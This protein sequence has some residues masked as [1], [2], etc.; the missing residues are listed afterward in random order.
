[1]G[2]ETTFSGIMT[3]PN[4]EK[5]YIAEM[6]VA[7]Q[8]NLWLAGSGTDADFEFVDDDDFE[9]VDEDD[10]TFVG[11]GVG[12]VYR[13]DFLDE[14]ITFSDGHTEYFR[15]ILSSI[16][17]DGVELTKKT[18][19][20]DVVSA[21]GSWYQDISTGLVYVNTTDSSNPNGHYI[22]GF[23]QLR[24]S[25]KAI[26]LDGNFYEPYISEKGI[27]TI[28]YRSKEIY[29]GSEVITS[30]SISLIN[31]DGFFDQIF[32]TFI[33]SSKQITIKLG[34]DQLPY[35]EYSTIFTGTIQG[36]RFT[37]RSVEF[38]LK[39]KSFDLFQSIPLDKFT[40]SVYVNM[41]PDKEGVPIPYYYGVYSEQQAPIVTCINTGAAPVYSFKIC[42]HP[43]YSI[44]QVYIDYNDG[45]GWQAIAHSNENL[46]YATFDISSADFAIGTTKV[47]VAFSGI[48][49]SSVV[50][51]PA[52][53]VENILT[54]I[55]SYTGAD[56]DST[57]FSESV[58]ESDVVLNV[59]K[60]FS[61]I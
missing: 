4:S 42:D 36:K 15:K 34:G 11:A 49:D 54:S 2:S 21:T 57:S 46:T 24:L 48:Y 59:V 29:W 56:I 55:L 60:M 32:R 44:S 25:T 14:T 20:A 31:N 27:P 50:E 6:V 45:D 19:S 10:F 16:T 9:F 58:T 53:I 8:L 7:Q 22:V 18:S 23:F 17:E 39:A 52:D 33:W 40:A 26:E 41:D 43:I 37:R 61:R 30:G 28:H 13:H 35:S 51:V 38:Q 12:V 1:M 5:I 47:K 3:S